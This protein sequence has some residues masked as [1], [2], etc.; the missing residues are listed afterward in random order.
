MN[1]YQQLTLWQAFPNIPIKVLK[2]IKARLYT[3]LTWI[4][5]TGCKQDSVSFFHLFFHVLLCVCF[6]LWISGRP[7]HYA[8]SCIVLGLQAHIWYLQK[9]GSLCLLLGRV[10][11]W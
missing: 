1:T 3:C 10:M 5:L 7:R 6:A 11:Q 9:V 2:A 4:D 8:D